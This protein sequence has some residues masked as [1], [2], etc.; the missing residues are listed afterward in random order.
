MLKNTLKIATVSTQLPLTCGIATYAADLCES[1]QNAEHLIYALH[2]GEGTWSDCNGNANVSS[3]QELIALAE[4]INNS[5][6]HV[7]NLQHEFGIWGGT[8]GEHLFEFLSALDLP[9]VSTLHT[10]YGPRKEDPIREGILAELASLSSFIVV[11]TP[12]AA[13]YALDRLKVTSTRLIEIPHGVPDIKYVSPRSQGRSPN[14]LRFA[15]IGYLRQDKGIDQSIRALSMIKEAGYNFEYLVAGGPQPQFSEQ[16][17]YADSL[18]RLVNDL[19]LSDHIAFRQEFIPLSEQILAVQSA[20][21][22]LFAYQTAFHSSSGAI[23]LAL[24]CGRP[25]LCTPIAYSCEKRDEVGNSI[26]ITN[27]F[28]IEDIF[29]SLLSIYQSPEFLVNLGKAAWDHARSWQWSTVANMYFNAF[30]EASS[31]PRTTEIQ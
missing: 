13:R 27:G 29:N 11:L 12:E 8:N 4:K 2:Y 19:D 21:V 23:P 16:R 24:A 5:G 28:A 26:F 7:V 20:D 30:V 10:T 6:A 15:S 31:A 1:L 18:L 14:F 9:V 25:V 3:P 17:S 22:A